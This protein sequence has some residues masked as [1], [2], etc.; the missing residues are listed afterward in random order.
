VTYKING[1]EQGTAAMNGMHSGML[2]EAF[3]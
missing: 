2:G 1:V 3:Y